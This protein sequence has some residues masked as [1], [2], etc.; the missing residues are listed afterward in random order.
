MTEQVWVVVRCKSSST[1]DLEVSLLQVGLRAWT[2]ASYKKRRLPRTRATVLERVAL[3]PSFVFIDIEDIDAS[4]GFGCLEKHF[5]KALTTGDGTVIRIRDHELTGLRE[6]CVREGEEDKPVSIPDV[7]SWWRF[8]SGPFS[9]HEA[10]VVE[11]N[12]ARVK[13]WLTY[14]AGMTLMVGYVQLSKTAIQI[15]PIA[16]DG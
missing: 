15:T 3:L 11:A 7:G 6:A 1:L 4:G 5:L 16:L 8:L 12:G 10:V 2:P 9:G 14:G 13:M